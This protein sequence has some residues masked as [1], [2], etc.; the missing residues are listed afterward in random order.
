MRGKSK[1]IGLFGAVLLASSA[2]AEHFSFDSDNWN[3]EAVEAEVVEYQGYESLKLKGGTA[4]LEGLELI[5]GVI[6]FDISVHAERS[7]SGCVFRLQDETNF[8]H[9]Y[10]RPHQS[11][12]PDANQYTPV[13]NGVSAWQLYHG[14]GF[15][16]PVQYRY[17]D[18]MHIKLV[19]SEARAE[20]YID[21]DEPTVKI[22]ELKRP[23][24]AGGVGLN[25]SNLSAT[26]FANVEVSALPENY[27]FSATSTLAENPAAGVVT[28]WLVSNTFSA[29]SL[30]GVHEL[31]E[32]NSPSKTWTPLEADSG[33]ITNL[34]RIQGLAENEDTVF[35]KFVITS[36]TRKIRALNF[37]YSD[38]VAVY[39]NN[40]LTYTGSN[41]Y[42]SRD[43]RYLGTIGM[44]D[45][46]YLQLKPGD[47]TV[48]FAVTEAFGGW[49]IKAQL[50][51]SDGLIIHAGH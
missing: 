49:G 29:E 32:S 12:N 10:I 38:S 2:N 3:I 13:F 37:G 16:T 47:N 44:F 7:F 24:L 17:D 26:Y 21:S 8:E 14:E 6:E 43:Y 46:V 18:W 23:V 51:D 45:T 19:F 48:Q 5:E 20:V 4:M 35:A 28:S 9:F 11:G 33:G 42:R 30:I 41:F 15:G 50:D 27:E 39:V 1:C 36:D 34:A 31:D 22:G 25:A 40:Q